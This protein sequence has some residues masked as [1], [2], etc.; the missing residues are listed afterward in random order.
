[1]RTDRLIIFAKEPAP[2]KVKTRLCPP[3]LPVEAAVLYEAFITD[4]LDKALSIKS[5]AVTMAYTPDDAREYFQRLSTGRGITVEP[6]EGPD[7]GARMLGAFEAAF[8]KG[9]AKAA[10]IGTDIPTLPVGVM[11][12]A[13]ARL[14]GYD[15]VF[16]PT[17]DG[18]YCLA[19]L[20]TPHKELFEGIEWSTRSVLADTLE[21]ARTLGLDVFLLPV[22]SDVD[23][24]GDLFALLEENPPP[25]TSSVLKGLKPR[26]FAG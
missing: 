1:L 2:G 19:A 14:D 15:A 23:T 11:R 25:A 5:C 22:Q 24:P 26:L 7:L 6:Q 17:R 12:E 13:F 8:I 9:A 21:R 20:K 16:A 10:L 3:L 4:T 18:G